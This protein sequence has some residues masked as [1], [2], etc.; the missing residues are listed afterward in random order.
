MV[1]L[2]IALKNATVHWW[3]VWEGMLDYGCWYSL[4]QKKQFF[5]NISLSAHSVTREIENTSSEVKE[6]L[7]SGM[8]NFE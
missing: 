2:L 8:G 7:K 3:R 5:E 6:K 4:S 1:S